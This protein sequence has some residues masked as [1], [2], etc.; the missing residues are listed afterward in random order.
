M[1]IKGKTISDIH[2]AVHAC[3]KFLPSCAV[4]ELCPHKAKHLTGF[5]KVKWINR[6]NSHI[7]FFRLSR[8]TY[9]GS[10]ESELIAI[11]IFHFIPASQSC[12][13]AHSCKRRT[14]PFWV[15][16][17]NALIAMILRSRKW[18]DQDW[19]LTSLPFLPSRFP[20]QP[21][22]IGWMLFLAPSTIPDNPSYL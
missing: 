12:G 16:F 17:A 19:M 1:S 4:R 11:S 6:L 10:G 2:P 22:R 21:N 9:L 8:T 18:K 15:C 3:W 5:P 20:K 14:L 7:S 13:N